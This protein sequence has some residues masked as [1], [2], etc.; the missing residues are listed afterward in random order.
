M[1]THQ[2]AATPANFARAKNSPA[3]AEQTS[4]RHVTAFLLKSRS[5]GGEMP[6]ARRPYC[7]EA[8]EP[9]GLAGAPVGAGAVALRAAL[10]RSNPVAR[11]RTWPE[12]RRQQAAACAAHKQ[13]PSRTAEAECNASW[14]SGRICVGD[15]GCHCAGLGGRVR[16]VRA[17]RARQLGTARAFR[18]T[19]ARVRATDQAASRPGLLARHSLLFHGALD[20]SPAA[21]PRS[22]TANPRP[23][24][25]DRKPAKPPSAA[26]APEGSAALCAGDGN[27]NPAPL[28]PESRSARDMPERTNDDKQG[29]N[30]YDCVSL[31]SLTERLTEPILLLMVNRPVHQVET[32]SWMPR[33]GASVGAIRHLINARRN[34]RSWLL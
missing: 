29:S 14:S 34:L 20:R 30:K 10:G 12:P 24:K 17:L 2:S 1:L 15:E 13:T 22:I 32:K 23:M 8:S 7:L 6:G 31:H 21:Q 16:A 28:N 4:A 25:T 3:V 27:T 9:S 11:R 33:P 18:G 19:T 5:L 26:R